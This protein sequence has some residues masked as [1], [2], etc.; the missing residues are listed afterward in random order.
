MCLQ[1][2]LSSGQNIG[3]LNS[4]L[5]LIEKQLIPA[6]W[7]SAAAVGFLFLYATVYPE[8]SVSAFILCH[9]GIM[10]QVM[11]MLS[12]AAAAAPSSVSVQAAGRC[13]EKPGVFSFQP[14]PLQSFLEQ[15]V[16]SQLSV[17]LR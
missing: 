8:K 1:I 4:T 6:F 9:P 7:G 16:R 11:N 10:A 3:I 13:A 5:S 12:C 15:K 17:P 14:S 2:P